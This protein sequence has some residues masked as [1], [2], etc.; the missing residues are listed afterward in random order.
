MKNIKIKQ[1]STW[2]IPSLNQHK[3]TNLPLLC[4]N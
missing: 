1:Y 4:P 2:S 3:T